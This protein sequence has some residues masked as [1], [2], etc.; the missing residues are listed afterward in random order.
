MVGQALDVAP[1]RPAV[2]APE[3]SGW[4]DAG[5]QRAAGPAGQAPDGRDLLGIGTLAIAQALGRVRPR[6]PAIPAAPDGRPEPR[7]ATAREDRAARRLEDEVVDRPA[8]AEWSL[9]G[10]VATGG[11]TVDDERALGRTDEQPGLGHR[12]TS[13]AA[14]WERISSRP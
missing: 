7:A 11:V 13:A 3:Q 1:G 9:D 2:V 5:V 14:G 10:P 12:D 4:L 6:R 8:L